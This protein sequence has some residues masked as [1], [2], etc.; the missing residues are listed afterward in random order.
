MSTQPKPAKGGADAHRQPQEKDE[1]DE[2]APPMPSLDPED[3]DGGG[4]GGGDSPAA[5][6]S[7]ATSVFGVSTK[8]LALAAGV[9]LAA[10]ILWQ[11]WKNRDTIDRQRREQREHDTEP[12]GNPNNPS[13]DEEEMPQIERDPDD[14]LAADHEAGKHIFDWED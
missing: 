3:R 10:F 14:P 2:H 12:E 7:G 8:K 11:L 4:G 5:P 9:L 6:G 1:D 13:V